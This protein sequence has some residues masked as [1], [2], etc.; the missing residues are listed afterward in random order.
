MNCV[1]RLLP[2]ALVFVLL[3]GLLP[4]GAL[5][6][7]PSTVEAFSKNAVVGQVIDFNKADFTSRVSGND[8]LQGIIVTTLPNPANGTLK[9]GTR[10]PMAG[11]AITAN[12]LDMLCYQPVGDAV[13]QDSFT[14]LP[15]FSHG[16][17]AGSVSVN[18]VTLD[19]PNRA[20]V[21]EDIALKTYKNVSVTG[22]FKATDPDNDPMTYRLSSKTKR[23]EL[24]VQPDGSFVYKPYQNKTGN[25]TIKYVAVDPYGNTS[26]IATLTVTIEKK[27]SEVSYS[28]M[29]GHPAQ[30][31]ALQLAEKNLLV[32]ERVGGEYF[33]RPDTPVTRAEFLAIMVNCLKLGEVS[34]SLRTGFADDEDIP[35]W[36]KPYVNLAVRCGY[37]NG[38]PRDD[39]RKVFKPYQPVTRSQASVMLNRSLSLTNSGLLSVFLND[40]NIADWAFQS[41][42]NMQSVGLLASEDFIKLDEAM[43]RADVALMLSAAVTIK[44][45]SQPKESGGLLDWVFG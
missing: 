27:S 37:I 41:V 30:Y 19:Q 31:A 18:L 39:G 43:T 36:A 20:P 33:F 7:E 24:T 9:N 29:D 14:F 1:R 26:P 38:M 32:G 8:K 25:D 13:Q 16:I 28:D 23:G 42:A 3:V 34:A 4:V 6:E 2:A 21:A 17:G 10:V 45:S 22:R 44:E 12:D 40:S 35:A 15:V 5:A 11:E